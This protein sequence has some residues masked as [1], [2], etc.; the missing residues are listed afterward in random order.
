MLANGQQWALHNAKLGLL[1]KVGL[2]GAK[3]GLL[4]QSWACWANSFCW[5]KAMPPQMA[6]LK[7]IAPPNFWLKFLPS[8]YVTSH[9]PGYAPGHAPLVPRLCPRSCPARAP[10]MPPA[11]PP[12]MPPLVPRSCPGYAPGYANA[13]APARPL[14][15]FTFGF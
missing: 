8:A 9:A 1:G 4:G 10:V 5:A 3:L 6:S 2:D 7:L 15:F 12:V 11:I 13:H 14:R